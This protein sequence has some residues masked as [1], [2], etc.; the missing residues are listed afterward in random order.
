MKNNYNDILQLS[1]APPLWWDENGV[2]R[3]K[4]FYPLTDAPLDTDEYV[5][6]EIRC[7]ECGK[8]YRVAI[9]QHGFS[10]EPDQLA[11]EIKVRQIDYGDPPNDCGEDC[12][13]GATMS[14]IPVRVIEYWARRKMAFKG[15]KRL[16]EFEVDFKLPQQGFVGLMTYND[17]DMN[18]LG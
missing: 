18:G 17:Y 10:T 14:S 9:R 1:A 7:Q 4:A 12:H 11:R 16:T 3:Y 2:P 5:L 8:I 15:W 13:A 6:T